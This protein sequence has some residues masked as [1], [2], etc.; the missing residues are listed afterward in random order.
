MYEFLS[1][2]L[3]LRVILPAALPSALELKVHDLKHSYFLGSPI[4]VLHHLQ[5]FLHFRF[6]TQ[7]YH[8]ELMRGY[9]T[10]EIF[11]GIITK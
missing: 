2:G 6:K 8:A 7:M 4:N 9:E 5:I 11:P 3:I 1:L 10:G